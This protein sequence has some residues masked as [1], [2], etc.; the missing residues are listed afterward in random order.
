[1]LWMTC[2]AGC[3]ADHEASVTSKEHIMAAKEKFDP[4]LDS[5]LDHHKEAHPVG[6]GVGATGGALA[7]AAVGSA[8]GPAGTL[9]GGVIG[10]VAG[11]LA[12]RGVAELVHP[13]SVE[14]RDFT[15]GEAVERVL[16]HEREDAYWREAHMAEPYYNPAHSY[17]DYAPAYRMGW[18]SRAKYDGGTFE[19]FEPAFRNDWENVKGPSRLGW[20]EARHAVRAGWDRVDEALPGDEGATADLSSRS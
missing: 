17:D 12:G 18:E 6:V 3:A 20:D 13:E 11:G 16:D 7:G 1:M 15:P 5:S 2:L 19:Q 10:A 9:V 8:G 4:S 14:R